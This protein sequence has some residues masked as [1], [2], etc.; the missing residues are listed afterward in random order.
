MIKPRFEDY[1]FEVRPL[2]AEDGGGLLISFPDLPGCFSDGDTHDE[3]IAN[4]R[5]AF[6]EWV[7]G[8]QEMGR[9]VPLP[10]A[11]DDDDPSKFVLRMPHSMHLRVMATASAEGVSANLLLTTIIAEGIAVRAPRKS[12]AEPKARYRVKKKAAK[13]ARKQKKAAGRQLD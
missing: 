10:N 12:I 13:P 6:Y 9:K 3:A 1:R 2:S 8:W 4:G 11:D 7:E 5:E